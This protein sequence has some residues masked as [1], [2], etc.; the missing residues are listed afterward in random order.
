MVLATTIV[1]LLLRARLTTTDVAMLYLLGVVIV[2]TRYHRGPSLL[3][4]LLSIALFDL[5]F[6]PPYGRFDVHDAAYILTFAMMLLVAVVMSRLT[7]RIREQAEAAGLRERRTTAL[8]ELSRELAGAADRDAIVH[9]ITGHLA[10]AAGADAAVVLAGD[11]E[12]LQI[13]DGSLL[14]EPRSR[15][16]ASWAFVHDTPAGWDTSDYPDLDVLLLPL[17]SPLHRHG[18]AAIARPERPLPQGERR[19]LELVVAQAGL[20]LERLLL[21]E[22][23]ERARVAMEAEHL[24]TT[25]LSSLSH[26][27]RTPLASI[28][29]AGTTLLDADVELPASVRRDLTET[30]VDEARRMTRLVANLLDMVR[31]ETG[32]LAVQRTWVPLEELVGVALLRLEQRLAAHPVD[33]RL[34]PDLPLVSVDDVLMEQV[35]VNL[36]ENA[37]RH[38]PPGTPVTVTAWQAEGAVVVEVADRGPGVAAGEEEA[39]FR[40]FYR[41]RST[42]DGTAPVSAV[43]AAGGSV[44]AGLGLAICRGIMTAHG[45]RIWVEPRVGGGAAFRLAI[46]LDR[47]QP[48]HPPMESDVVDAL[49]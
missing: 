27:L 10:R 14:A 45:G 32:T 11:G 17:R 6:V 22:E 28:E 39:V 30:I 46:P 36:L 15:E 16:A 9:V 20:A 44:G 40:K 12:T 23:Q 41:V 13:A 47:P 29:G 5:G 21:A 35:L 48:A 33:V 7:A 8:Y 19:I 43:S 25:L 38:T 1:G 3:A 31:L 42:T 18:V 34:P 37:A 2:A 26:D 4:S 24:R 49:D